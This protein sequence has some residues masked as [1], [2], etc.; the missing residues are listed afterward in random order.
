VQS[1]SLH[2]T[3]ILET[4]HDRPIVTVECYC[5]VGIADSVAAFRS[6][7]WEDILVSYTN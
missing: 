5:K 2:V 7:A 3:Y 1:V 6:S 4:K